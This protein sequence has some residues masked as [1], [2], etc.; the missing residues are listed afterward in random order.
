V[1]DLDEL[2]RIIGPVIL[3]DVFDLELLWPDNLPE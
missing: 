1:I 2:F 3:I